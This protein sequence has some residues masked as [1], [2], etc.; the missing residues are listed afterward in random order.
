MTKSLKNIRF[1]YFSKKANDIIVNSETV[2]F[3]TFSVFLQYISV[4][5]HLS[6]TPARNNI[7]DI[8]AL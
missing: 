5:F 8:L 6:F 2:S 4:P 1:S 3:D 7:K